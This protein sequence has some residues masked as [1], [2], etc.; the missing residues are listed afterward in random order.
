MGLIFSKLLLKN[1]CLCGWEFPERTGLYR[2]PMAEG[3]LGQK[4]FRP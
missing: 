3:T 2:V 4:K 1:W